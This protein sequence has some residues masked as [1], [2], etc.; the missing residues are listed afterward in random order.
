MVGASLEGIVF[1]RVL[2]GEKL[3][4]GFQSPEVKE[5]ETE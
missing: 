1:I 3:G 4:L 2:H 5:T